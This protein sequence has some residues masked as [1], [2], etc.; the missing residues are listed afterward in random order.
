MYYTV[1][2]MLK[3]ISSIF[4]LVSMLFAVAPVTKAAKVGSVIGT[5]YHT[6]IVAY[7]NNYAIPSYAA[8]GTSVVVAEDL[9][10]YGFDVTWNANA[11]TLSINRNSTVYPAGMNFSKTGAPSSKF[12]NLL[13]T[14]IKV[15]ANGI[16]IPSYAING[17]TMIPLESL[18]MFGTYNWVDYQRA[19]KLWIDGLYVRKDMQTVNRYKLSETEAARR[20][21]EW[22]GGSLGS[23]VAGEPN[24]LA[25]NGKYTCNGKEYYEF[26][27]RGIVCDENRERF[28]STTLTYYVISVDG[29]DIFDGMCSNGY[30]DRW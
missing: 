6:D 14:D 12:A 30:L 9:R 3:K 29:V 27:L 25:Y 11:R 28:W 10:N 19:L 24:V 18:T 21:T 23:W 16:K 4:I 22:V 5:V 13:Y 7:I 1:L 15:Y 2:T 8:N 20:I 17:Y 26:R